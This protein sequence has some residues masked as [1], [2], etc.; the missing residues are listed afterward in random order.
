MPIPCQKPCHK[1]ERGQTAEERSISATVSFPAV[2]FRC[3]IWRTW[4]VINLLTL[5][6]IV[7]FFV[8]KWP[9]GSNGIN[10]RLT[11]ERGCTVKI[12]LNFRELTARKRR[13]G[14]NAVFLQRGTEWYPN[15]TRRSVAK[16]CLYY[17]QKTGRTAIPVPL[18]SKPISQRKYREFLPQDCIKRAWWYNDTFHLTKPYLTQKQR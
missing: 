9:P 8:Q 14:Q 17:R 3:A 12:P 10:T 13:A 18:A 1:Y 11:G 4:R 2:V 15:T 5:A 6:P 7:T 16:I